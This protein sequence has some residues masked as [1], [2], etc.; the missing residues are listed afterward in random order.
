MTTPASSPHSRG[1]QLGDL[2][3]PAELLPSK[4]VGIASDTS[5]LPGALSVHL[6]LVES[7]ALL[8]GDD[9]ARS[10]KRVPY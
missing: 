5:R 1:E 3:S 9:G 10:R 8:T 4:M 6:S 7:P 2:A